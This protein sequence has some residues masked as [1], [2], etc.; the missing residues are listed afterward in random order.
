MQKDNSTLERK[1]ALRLRALAACP[2]GA[3]VLET[4][5]GYGRIGERCYSDRPGLV[6]EKDDKK[7]EHLARAR[8]TWRVYQGDC[9]MSLAAGLGA[10]LPFALIDCDPYGSPFAVLD[11]IFAYQRALAP[12]LQ[13]VVNDG[14]R[15]G[16]QI[17]KSWVID[18]LKGA[19]AR[20]GNNLYP[21]YLEIAR[22]LVEELAGK[23]GFSLVHWRG[24]YCGHANGM[25]HYW[26]TS[27]QMLDALRAG[28]DRGEFFLEYLPTIELATGRCIGAEALTRWNQDGRVH[29]PF[30]FDGIHDDYQLSGRI[31]F[32]VIETV[33]AELGDWL[34]ENPDMHVSINLPPAILGRGAIE[35]AIRRAGLFDVLP[36]LIFELTEHGIPDER[37]LKAME[38]MMSLGA[39][40][41]LDD[42]AFNYPATVLLFT[43]VGVHIVKLPKSYLDSLDAHDMI[44]LEQLIK[45]SGA[46][47]ISEGVET[48]AQL[49]DLRGLGVPMGQGWLFSKSIPADAFL[50]YW[51]EFR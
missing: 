27:D 4:H 50:R 6:I 10:D 43:R 38:Y 39:R 3:P 13:V 15:Q 42:I 12:T 11:S 40:F 33:A 41:A 24:Y 30:S 18:A 28:L 47:V 14:L 19:V 45:A 48:P 16:V 29:R 25:T 2:P 35:H 34:R 1:V 5:G 36:Q 7:A 26:A 49:E 44:V 20:H 37:G 22:E 51:A 23:A 17:G 32:W 31:T 9:E 8:P 46:L 21:R